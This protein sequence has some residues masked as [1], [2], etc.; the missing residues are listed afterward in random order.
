MTCLTSDESMNILMIISKND[1]YGAQR[2]FLDQADALHRMGHQVVVVGR[3]NDGFVAESARSLGV[4]YFGIPMKGLKDI[5]Y[6]RRLVKKYT[7]D[8]IHTSLDRADYFGVILS[9]LSRT[10]RVSTMNVRRYHLGYRFADRVV[11][12]S[13]VQKEMLMKHG[14]P[15]ERIRI[16]R[17]WIDAQRYANPVPERRD[18]WK[19]KLGT[20]RFSIVFC[21][22][23]SI[24]PQKNHAVSLDLI[25]ACRERG[26][27]P[28]LIIAGDPLRGSHYDSLVKKIADEGLAEHVYFTG[29]TAE[30]PE[31]L[32]LSHFTVLPSVHEAFG[33]VLLE[34][35][36][37]GTPIVASSGEGGAELIEEYGTGLL[38]RQEE[39]VP[40]L[41]DELLDLWKDRD[42]YQGMSA[43]CRE[44][45]R[46]EFSRD[47]FG[48]QLI[49]L[50]HALV[51]Q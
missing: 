19:Q 21:H 28:L 25:A 13:N 33:M 27:N 46:R 7:M 12:V 47:R 26:E 49:G 17:P 3:G 9:L 11:T 23:S 30:V 15:A 34:G 41:A 37:A 40:R 43:K 42:R 14:I 44:V 6:L 4:E 18:A 36:A 39:G 2:V 32:A 29:W 51:R 20:D 1:K 22:V 48:E 24:L 10:P 35:M 50:Y 45:C 5:L 8:V 38:Y 16:I 31:L